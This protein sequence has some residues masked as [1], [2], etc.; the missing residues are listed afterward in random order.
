MADGV[1]MD[2]GPGPHLTLPSYLPSCSGSP[3]HQPAILDSPAILQAARGDSLGLWPGPGS[4]GAHMLCYS[5]HTLF[6]ALRALFSA[7]SSS[8]HV[9]L[10]FPGAKGDFEA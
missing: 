4:P 5:S 3:T 6:P 2:S 1:G 7:P 10:W 9:T 8:V